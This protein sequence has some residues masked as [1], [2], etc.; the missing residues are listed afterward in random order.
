MDLIPLT[1]KLM[2]LTISFSGLGEILLDNQNP[3]LV[4]L[5]KLAI[6]SLAE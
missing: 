3:K 1:I 2:L 6:P 5:F 4:P